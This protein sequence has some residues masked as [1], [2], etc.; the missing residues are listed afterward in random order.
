M[1]GGNGD[2]GRRQQDTSLML[3][4]FE[5]DSGRYLPG[6]NGDGGRRQQNSSLVLVAF[7]EDSR[8]YLPDVVGDDV[9]GFL[10][11]IVQKTIAKW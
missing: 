10:K 1:P 4:A 9:K 2:G 6:G 8:I 5:E 7:Q 11:E 3:V